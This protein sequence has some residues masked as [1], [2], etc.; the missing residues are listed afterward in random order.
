M[1]STPKVSDSLSVHDLPDLHL[2]T[3]W[4]L[5]KL[6][7]DSL[8]R[9]AASQV[10]TYLV[11]TCGVNTYRQAVTR[12][13]EKDSTRCHKNKVGYKL[14]EPGRKALAALVFNRVVFIESGKPFS[15][16]NIVLRELFQR[17]KNRILICDPYLDIHTLDILFKHVDK[18][19]PLKIL[20]RNITDK[21][22]GTFHRHLGELR[23]EGF[24]IQ[25]GQHSASELHDR[26]IMDDS[27]F[28]LSGN[29]LNYLGNKESFL[30]ALGD[31][32]RQSMLAL[33]NSRWS[34]A[35][36]I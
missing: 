14:M 5:E 23:R 3:L 17:L 35:S 20:T 34:A 26:Y 8:D 30:V 21:P 27:T 18:S 36:I 31:D 6:S 9:F 28:W 12:A 2:K 29:S 10:A 33:F 22:P 11:E 1:T 7:V 15:T 4:A 25:V 19:I 13:L 16:K 24:Q 32:V